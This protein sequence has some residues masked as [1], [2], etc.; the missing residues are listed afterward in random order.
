MRFK[1]RATNRKRRGTQ[2][3]TIRELMVAKARGG[4][5]T[6]KEIADRT[7]F[8]EASISAQLRHLRKRGHG[9]YCVQKRVR[10]QIR[11]RALAGPAV[12]RGA[13][14]EYRVATRGRR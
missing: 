7:E 14:W 12:C 5:L 9:N 8:A 11:R 1:L 13:T 10:K 4:W 2:L 6:L 3:A